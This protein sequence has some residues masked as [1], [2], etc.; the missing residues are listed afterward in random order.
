MDH[1]TCLAFLLFIVLTLVITLTCHNTIRS[2]CAGMDHGTCLAFLIYIVLTLVITLTC[3][4]TIRS[5][6]AGMD[7]G[8][9]GCSNDELCSELLLSRYSVN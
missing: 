2:R 4:N 9:E 3:H 6:C 8:T 5:R 7:H 1:G